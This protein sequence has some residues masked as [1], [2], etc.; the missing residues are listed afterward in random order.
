MEESE[1]G[2]VYLIESNMHLTMNETWGLATG[3]FFNLAR[4]GKW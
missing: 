4:V 3:V 2:L 1:G